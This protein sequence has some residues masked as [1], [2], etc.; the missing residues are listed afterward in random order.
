MHRIPCVISWSGGKDC[1]LALDEIIREQQYDIRYLL[2]TFHLP[3]STVDMHGI[4]ETLIQAQAEALN[5]PLKKIFI[6]EKDNTSYEAALEKALL[7]LKEEGIQ[8]I[9]FGDIFLE[10]LR[11]YR[12]KL[13]NRLG[14]DC[15]FPLWKKDSSALANQFIENKFKAVVC[16][17][18]LSVLSSKHAGVD[19]DK[20]FLQQ[21][22]DGVDPCGENGEFH[23]YCFDGPLFK[24][25]IEIET[26]D[27]HI[28]EAHLTTINKKDT[29]SLKIGFAQRKFTLK[30]KSI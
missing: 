12:E 6:P 25:K 18:N 11:V 13:F 27:I 23:T 19:Y 8:T 2:T 3:A 29:P 4:H 24:H 20:S 28:Q 30:N 7:P 26:G 1:N 14:F 17:V 9:I 5:I 22:P 21:L 10:D 15:H 16:S